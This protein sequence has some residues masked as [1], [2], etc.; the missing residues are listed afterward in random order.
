MSTF[1]IFNHLC[2]ATRAMAAPGASEAHR[3]VGL[4]TRGFTLIEVMIV[5]AMIGIL[6]AIAVPGYSQYMTDGRR[7][8]A[9]SFLS[10]V[11]GEQ[12]RYFSSNNRY[13]DSMDE[14]GYGDAA[15]FVTPEGHYTVSVTNPGSRARFMLTATPVA[16][17]RQAGDTEC[18][19][20]TITDTGVKKNTG[21]NTDCW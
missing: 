4:R 2:C 3:S 15:T 8:D 6:A 18:L 5:V 9:I 7:T 20:F 17:G 19:A 21:T 16:D 14:L 1:F 12:V 10:E 13:A 11:A